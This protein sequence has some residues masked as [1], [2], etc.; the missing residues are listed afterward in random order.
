M[1]DSQFISFTLLLGRRRIYWSS[2]GKASRQVSRRA[3]HEASVPTDTPMVSSL[4]W[5]NTGWWDSWS[6]WNVTGEW[7]LRRR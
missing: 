2:L 1:N 6:I 5:R 4:P 3:V 7:Y